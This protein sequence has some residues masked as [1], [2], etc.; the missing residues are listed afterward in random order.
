[1]TYN[2]ITLT[3][4]YRILFVPFAAIL[5]CFAIKDCDLV[6]WNKLTDFMQDLQL[7]KSKAVVLVSH[8]QKYDLLTSEVEVNIYRVLLFHKRPRGWSNRWSE[9]MVF[10]HWFLKYTLK[11]LFLHNGN[12]KRFSPICHVIDNKGFSS[13]FYHPIKVWTGRIIW[14]SNSLREWNLLWAIL[15][16]SNLFILTYLRLNRLRL[17]Y[18]KTFL[19]S[20]L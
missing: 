5:I 4:I 16:F 14:R 9:L 17:R 10:V 15:T 12:K 19:D 6:I 2:F 20:Q 18:I 7:P 3:N 1:M 8:S 13:T 11:V